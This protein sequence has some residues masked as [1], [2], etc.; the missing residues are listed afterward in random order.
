MVT[1]AIP[2]VGKEPAPARDA[3][4]TDYLVSLTGP[5]I[6]AGVSAMGAIFSN[7]SPAPST[8]GAAT[9]PELDRPVSINLKRTEE[10]IDKVLNDSITHLKINIK[11][12]YQDLARIS[13][14]SVEKMK[15]MFSHSTYLKERSSVESAV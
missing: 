5:I 10:D 3:S 14:E 4:S 8:S 13:N 12:K 6:S 9:K 1:Q 7:D 11:S 2:V 15:E